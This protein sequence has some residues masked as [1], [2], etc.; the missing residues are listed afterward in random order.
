MAV[1]TTLKMLIF[2]SGKSQY[3]LAQKLGMSETRMSRISSGRIAPT[4]Y[5]AAAIAKH[6][7]KSA[8]EIFPPETFDKAPET[9]AIVGKKKFPAGKPR[10]EEFS[11]L[12][13]RQ[14]LRLLIDAAPL[15]E[16]DLRKERVSSEDSPNA[17]RDLL[18]RKRCVEELKAK[19][20]TMLGESQ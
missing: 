2:T 19:V 18:Y 1:N 16:A 7:D 6:F 13:L 12:E 5:E 20:L 9:E 14:L 10:R 15:I 17:K 4:L 8:T 11:D 3:E